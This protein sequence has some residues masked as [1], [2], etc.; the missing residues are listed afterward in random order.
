MIHLSAGKSVSP[1]SAIPILPVYACFPAA[2]FLLYAFFSFSLSPIKD[3]ASASSLFAGGLYCIVLKSSI[4]SDC[5]FD[6]HA[7]LFAL[8]NSNRFWLLFRKGLTILM[9]FRI[10]SVFWCF[11]K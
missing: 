7:I 6:V 2:V 1:D 10:A 11:P 8:K 5:T 3:D 9:L 4:G